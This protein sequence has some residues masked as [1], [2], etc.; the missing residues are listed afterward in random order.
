MTVNPLLVKLLELR[1]KF[2]NVFW[3]ELQLPR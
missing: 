2:L 3:P 1:L